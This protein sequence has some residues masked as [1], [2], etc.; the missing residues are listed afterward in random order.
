MAGYKGNLDD[1][2]YQIIEKETIRII[3]EYVDNSKDVCDIVC[4]DD[5]LV[6]KI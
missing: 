2:T 4:Y 5:Y 3:N 1:L 6:Y